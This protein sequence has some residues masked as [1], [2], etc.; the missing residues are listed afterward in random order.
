MFDF[1]KTSYVVCLML[2]QA[3]ETSIYTFGTVATITFVLELTLLMAIKLVFIH[4]QCK[5]VYKS[6]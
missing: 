2:H 3:D 6:S 1:Q 5:A 4:W